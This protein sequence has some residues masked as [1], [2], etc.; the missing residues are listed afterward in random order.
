MKKQKKLNKYEHHTLA[1]DEFDFH[2]L[3]ILTEAEIERIAHDFLW[4]AYQRRLHKIRIITG[5][6][7]HS[8]AGGVIKP[9]L[10]RYIPTLPFVRTVGPAKQNEGGEGAL[11]ITL[12]E[13][14]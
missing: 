5:K 8:K 1:E 3:G 13:N 11:D 4:Q 10:S 2:G 6:G 12:E 14:P 7:L 9:I